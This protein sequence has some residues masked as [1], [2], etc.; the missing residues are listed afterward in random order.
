MNRFFTNEGIKRL[1]VL[2]KPMLVGSPTP[3]SRDSSNKWSGTVT[4]QLCNKNSFFTVFCAQPLRWKRLPHLG[5][6]M[7]SFT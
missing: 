3:G 2:H 6:T 7:G 5:D 4:Q 1:S